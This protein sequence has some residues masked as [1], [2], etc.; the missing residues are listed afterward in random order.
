[1]R[2]KR[3]QGSYPIALFSK[4]AGSGVCGSG[5][6]FGEGGEEDQAAD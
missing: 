6:H 2:Q 4:P 3:G 5:V 1:M